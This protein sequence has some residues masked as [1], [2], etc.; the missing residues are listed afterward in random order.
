MSNVT[1]ICGIPR[2]AGGMPSRWNLPS[3]RLS[4]AIGRSP[5]RMW[6][7]TEGWLSDAVE[8]TSLFFVGI[9]VFG[10]D[11][12]GHHA[13]ERLDPQRQRRHVQQEHVRD[14]AR[15]DA[16]LDRRPDGHDLIGV[17]ALVGLPPE[18]LAH[19]R[20]HPRERGSCRRPG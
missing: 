9:V 5:W 17:D 3:V 14:V 6:I 7:S 2:G 4:M 11:Q 20:L 19:E 1:S 13:A 15:E 18:D 8:K 10:I 12:L 16:A